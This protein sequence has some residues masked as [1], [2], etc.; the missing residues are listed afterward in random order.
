MSVDFREFYAGQCFG[1]MSCSDSAYGAEH[2]GADIDEELE[3]GIDEELFGGY[4]SGKQK[5]LKANFIRLQKLH[6]KAG[7]EHSLYRQFGLKKAKKRLAAIKS[8]MA[9]V[10][11]KI[12]SIWRTMETDAKKEWAKVH[13]GSSKSPAAF[14][15]KYGPHK[16]Q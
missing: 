15:K 10:M 13:K 7:K 5:R 11:Y 9:K 16:F 8:K 6:K 4:T 12:A 3:S 14:I 1:A 2:V